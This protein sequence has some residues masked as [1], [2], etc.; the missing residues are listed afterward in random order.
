[1]GKRGLKA[2]KTGRSKSGDKFARMFLATMQCPAWRALS[3][4]AQRL[5]PWLLLEWKGS[6]D[7]NNRR[8]SLSVRDA[9][10]LICS[11]NE[12]ARLALID[13]QKKGFIVVTRCAAL[14]STGNAR[15]HEY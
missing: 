5:Y 7:N 12:T 1:M 10:D 8:I 14:G 2:D 15:G 11:H 9:A 13:L 6:H 4:Y 3:P